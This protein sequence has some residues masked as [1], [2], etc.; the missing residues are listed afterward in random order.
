M[1]GMP[2]WSSEAKHIASSPGL[3]RGADIQKP[4]VTLLSICPDALMHGYSMAVLLLIQDLSKLVFLSGSLT[5]L[6][7]LVCARVFITQNRNQCRRTLLQLFPLKLGAHKKTAGCC[8]GAGEGQRSR[9]W[10]CSK[11]LGNKDYL[12]SPTQSL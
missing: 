3:L 11:R 6:H 12:N 8:E 4:A 5:E 10:A 7:K 2:I 1:W 9:H